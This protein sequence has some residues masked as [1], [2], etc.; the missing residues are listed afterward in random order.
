[1]AED[2]AELA[3][4]L[5]IDE[6]QTEPPPSLTPDTLSDLWNDYIHQDAQAEF[7]TAENA[8]LAVGDHIR[9]NGGVG[10]DEQYEI[11][12]IHSDGVTMKV[13]ARQKDARL[14]ETRPQIVKYLDGILKKTPRDPGWFKMMFEGQ[15]IFDDPGG[16]VDQKEVPEYNDPNGQFPIR[17][18]GSAIEGR[19]PRR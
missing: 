12:A 9:M 14:P 15:W 18:C 10:P 7:T 8:G 17:L 13:K 1:M 2:K 11:T 3:R 16:I 6:P 4:L 5:S 19:S